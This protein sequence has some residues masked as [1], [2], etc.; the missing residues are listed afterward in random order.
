MARLDRPVRWWH[1][2]GSPRSRRI[3][4]L[5]LLVGGGLRVAW[6]AHAG[7]APHFA[8]DP[9]AY[10]LQGE[11]LARGKGYT[12]PLID[13]ENEIRKRAHQPPLA[14][15]PSSFYPPGYPVFIAGVAWV[16][17]HS[18]IADG[19]VVR[20]VGYAQAILG[21]LTILL[22]FALAR[23]VFGARIGLVAAAIVAVYPNLITTTATLQLETVFIALS[24]ATLLVL[25][26]AA[27]GAD[28]RVRRLVA[29]GAM[30]G[31]VALVRP[32][33]ALLLFAFL[34]TRLLA[35]RP[36]R[37]TLA[38][39]ATVAVA[40]VAVVVPWTIRNA[41]ELHAFVPIST[42]I[43]PALCM[44]R[45]VEA[46]GGLDTGIL[47]RR[48][49]PAHLPASTAKADGVVNTYATRQAI[50]WVVH[51]PLG[52]LRM[53]F[54][55]TDLAYQRDTS[56][57][58]DFGGS[59]DPRWRGVAAALS[60]GAAYVVLGF[61]AIGVVMLVVRRRPE[62]TFLLGSAVA[63]A[64][65]PVIL[66]GDPRY[67]V[68]AEPLFAILAAAGLCVAIDEARRGPERG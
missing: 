20:A 10:L 55:R 25:L 31:V 38:A 61:A 18:P 56:G 23:R 47:E 28:P 66:F 57:L 19:S 39:F 13:I 34:V 36:W 12:N 40:M 6:V 3:L 68:P 33:I 11:T 59:M 9:E 65:V 22:V 16:V 5:V 63:F 44:S 32:T 27:T 30:T 35:R 1:G 53:W 41:V 64:A 21:V 46:T 58:D 14:R 37:E 26:P 45:N 4:L 8:G 2:I 62:G 51:H 17:W 54:W 50:Q 52:E 49:K 42:G 60:D 7:V 24:L 43:G 48:C 29:G 15:Q 67:R